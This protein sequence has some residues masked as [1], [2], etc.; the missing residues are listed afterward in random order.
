MEKIVAYFSATGTTKEV[1]EKI[2]HFAK[3]DLFEIKP[4][5]K[6]TDADLDWQDKNSRSSKPTF[7]RSLRKERLCSHRSSP[8]PLCGSVSHEQYHLKSTKPTFLPV[9]SGKPT[10]TTAFGAFRM[11]PNGRKCISLLPEQ[12]ALQF[13]TDGETAKVYKTHIPEQVLPGPSSSPY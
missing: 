6:Y 3:A 11:V 10:R 7:L 13:I 2:A 1:A 9:P 4:S 12:V 5:K 8:F